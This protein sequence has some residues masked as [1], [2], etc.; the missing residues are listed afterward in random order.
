MRR[1]VV[2]KKKNFKMVGSPQRQEIDQNIVKIMDWIEDEREE[3]DCLNDHLVIR[4]PYVETELK[5]DIFLS[6]KRKTGEDLAARLKYELQQIRPELRIFLDVDDQEE[7]QDLEIIVRQSK[8][9]IFLITS[10]VFSSVYVRH[11]IETAVRE[12]KKI[13]LVNDENVKIPAFSSIECFSSPQQK[14]IF[15]EVL[16]LKSI[17]YIR[18]NPFRKLSL[19]LILK[20]LDSKK[21][22]NFVI[23]PEKDSDDAIEERNVGS[24]IWSDFLLYIFFFFLLLILH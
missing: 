5:Y 20:K 3:L 11:E 13:I 19:Q 9:V 10:E 6:H 17:S 8:C 1:K 2:E 14:R 15:K 21:M 24:L 4:H 22:E 23:L 16:K 12:G 7:V 18:Q